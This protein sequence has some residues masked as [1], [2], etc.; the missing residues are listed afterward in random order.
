MQN[1][2]ELKQKGHDRRK[3]KTRYRERG[4]EYHFKKGGGEYIL[5]LDQNISPSFS[6]LFFLKSYS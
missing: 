5:F 1:Q 2:E 4:G 3:K 6:V